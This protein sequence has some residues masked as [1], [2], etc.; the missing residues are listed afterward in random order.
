MIK[1]IVVDD[2]RIALESLAKKLA[3]IDGVPI[4]NKKIMIFL[5]FNIQVIKKKEVFYKKTSSIT[6][7]QVGIIEGRRIRKI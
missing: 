1:P 4:D 2:E 7:I 3:R 6:T 5:Y